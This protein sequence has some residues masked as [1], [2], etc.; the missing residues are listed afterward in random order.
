MKRN[1]AFTL[2]ELLVVIGLIVVIVALLLPSVRVSREAA[3]RMQCSNNLKQVI[4]ALHYYHEMNGHFPPAMGGTDGATP[5][6]GNQGRLS[7]LVALLPYLERN[8]EWEQL[9]SPSTFDGI[10]YPAMGPAPWVEEYPL[11]K[12]QI[13]TYTCPTALR[14]AA[15]S[16]ARTN[17]AFCIG[18]MTQAIHDPP[19]VRG[20][21][22]C[23]R[24]TR[25]SDVA[26]GTSNTIA[27]V[28]I[29]S[30]NERAVIG[31][32]AVNQS[33][34]LLRKPA[35]CRQTLDRSG[36]SYL[37]TVALSKVGRGGRWA[38][39]AAG[40][41]LVNTILPPN[42][43]S[44]AVGGEEA[45]DGIYSAGS[46]HSSGVQVA[47]GDGSVRFINED[48][49]AGDPNLPPPAPSKVAKGRVR[50]PYGV[51]GALGTAAGEEE[52]TSDTQGASTADKK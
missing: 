8:A 5:L 51:W 49:D 36:K 47:M 39:G 50:S 13:P 7:G 48:I 22:A 32:Y 45:V 42:S 4:Y 9:S 23:G 46:L 37:S 38:D 26:D 17:Y 18:D 16:A 40:M 6:S 52:V 27:L 3:R 12:L 11:W 2:V 31:Q 41:S 30:P 33:Q 10:D 28:E 19:V 20:M 44:C 25:M 15:A 14:E 21:F 43:P 1:R 29:G 35:L 34:G 24:T